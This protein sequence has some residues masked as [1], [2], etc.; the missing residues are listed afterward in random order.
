MRFIFKAVQYS[1]NVVGAFTAVIII[2]DITTKIGIGDASLY[3]LG[4]LVS[5]MMMT[6]RA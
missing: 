5:I 4:A 1:I 3:A 6:F 2:L